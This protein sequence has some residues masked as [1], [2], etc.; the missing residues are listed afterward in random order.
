M[1]TPYRRVYNP[2]NPD[3]YK[4]NHPP[5]MR[6]SWEYSFAKW[7][8]NNPQVVKWASEETVIPYISKLDNRVHKYYT[9]F[10]V[11]FVGDRVVVFEIKPKKETQPPIKRSRKSKRY[12]TEVQTYV[13]NIS[14]W[15]AAKSFAKKHD[16]SF[17]I[18]TE[19]EL[20]KLG[21]KLV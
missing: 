12:L 9:D 21:I 16:I 1:T 6:S 14:K 19:V 2:R 8:D 15:E 13:R 4:G 17:Q 18:L 5:I 3:K 20:K 7:L 11:E 10:T